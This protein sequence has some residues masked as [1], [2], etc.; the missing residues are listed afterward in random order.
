MPAAH[1]LLRIALS[2]GFE[3][4]LLAFAQEAGWG[5]GIAI[6]EYPGGLL[7]DEP[8]LPLREVE[9][10]LYVQS[11]NLAAVSA[12]LQAWPSNWPGQEP[13]LRL[14]ASSPLDLSQD[15]EQAWQ[16]HWRPFRCAGFALAAEFL[17]PQRLPLRPE[18]V[19][20]RLVPGSAFGSGAHATTRMALRGLRHMWEMRHPR[21]WLDVGTGSGILAVAA[22]RLGA[23]LA[24]GMDPEAASAPQVLRMASINGV[25]SR[26]SAWRGGLD[27][28]R[29]RW[30]AIVANLFSDL[31][32]DAAPD[33]ARL[34]E[35]GGL[36]YAGGVVDRR[37]E[38]TS[39]ALRRTGLRHRAT[40]S[41]GRW[42]GALWQAPEIVN[43]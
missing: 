21:R 10:H 8:D 9:V 35:P 28:V 20:L 16:S 7:A 37:E 12:A 22:A 6:R 41:L 19:L 39:A 33:L 40:S 26:V 23:D 17:D 27:S 3:D 24:V 1:C 4:E 42:R 34:L 2:A 43:D 32:Q 29:G 30:P 14:L 18:D 36:L 11:D 13:R 15:P 25:A 31:L 5:P 38:R